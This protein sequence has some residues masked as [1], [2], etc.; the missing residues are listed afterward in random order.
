MNGL[1]PTDISAAGLYIGLNLLILL[2]VGINVS[3]HRRAS[4]T[5]LGEGDG[6]LKQA[7]RAFGNSAEWLPGALLG[8]AVTA[9]LGGQAIAV[10][11]L[12]VLLTAGRL[13][14]VWGILSAP[15]PNIGRI[16]GMVLTY[17]V[18]LALGLGLIAHAV[19]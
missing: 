15:G 1:A 12:G 5:S 4:Q 14:F 16:S 7:C 18:Y 6:Q 2:V 19:I 3:R 9:H 10:H 17:L 11:V 8:L 13:L